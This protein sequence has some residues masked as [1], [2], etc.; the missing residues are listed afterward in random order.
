MQ[1]TVGI[2]PKVFPAEFM[3]TMTHL[4]GR[5]ASEFCFYG[6][7]KEFVILTGEYR[8]HSSNFV[9]WKYYEIFSLMAE[10]RKSIFHGFVFWSYQM[11][12]SLNFLLDHIKFYLPR[13]DI[14]KNYHVILQEK[15]TFRFNLRFTTS[16]PYCT[17]WNISC[18]K[19][20]NVQ[21]VEAENWTFKSKN[22]ASILDRNSGIVKFDILYSHNEVQ[23]FW[24]FTFLNIVSVTW[25]PDDATDHV[26]LSRSQPNFCITHE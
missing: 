14:R 16:I 5:Y 2:L 19:L 8:K 1:K 4:H 6:F 26:Q 7:Q 22:S 11:F 18:T 15:H 3:R 20:K 17:R 9:A 21:L 23:I 12:H 10:S 13:C 25:S 24:K